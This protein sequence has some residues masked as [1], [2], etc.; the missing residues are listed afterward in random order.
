MQFHQKQT[1]CY[2][3]EKY[4]IHFLHSYECEYSIFPLVQVKSI[5]HVWPI[6]GQVTR[7]TT[8]KWPILLFLAGDC[9][10]IR[11]IKF[12]PPDNGRY[13]KGQVF[14]NISLGIHRQCEEQCLLESECVSINIGPAR[15][16]KFI[17]ELSNSDHVQHPQDLKQRRDWTYRG[18]EV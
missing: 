14:L 2:F 8:V 3:H 1:S 4:H 17:C 7:H 6:E 13:L 5:G 11:R 10:E 12:Y 15:N 18:I 9:E 16:D